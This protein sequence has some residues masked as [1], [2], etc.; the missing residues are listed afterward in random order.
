LKGWVAL[1]SEAAAFDEA[2]D[3]LRAKC[4]KRA[5]LF[6]I[7]SI[8]FGFLAFFTFGIT[9]ILFVPALVLTIVYFVKKGRL[10]KIDLDN[11]FRRVLLPFLET[12]AEDIPAEGRLR[13]ELDLAGPVEAKIVQRQE[14]PP[15]RFR[16]VL[17]TVYQDPWCRAEVPLMDGSRLIL[18]IENTFV[19]QD[20]YW[21][22]PRGKSKHKTKWKK[23]VSATAGLAPAGFF[24]FDQGLLGR[25][26]GGEKLKLKEKQ[27]A[28]IARLTR[29]FKFKAVN[30][31]PAETIGPDAL[32]A[33]FFQLGSMLKQS[34]AGGNQA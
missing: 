5:I 12:I 15:G 13:L 25:E 34:P 29:K 24:D 19:T 4:G 31:Q 9:L 27:G 10:K 22:N 8:A 26:A 23:L 28:E 32:L 18:D 1:L 21:R 30:A 7:L 11:E 3:E 20:R 33:M 6:L 2:A 14:I 16:K 17:E